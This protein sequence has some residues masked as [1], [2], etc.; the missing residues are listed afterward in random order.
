M[1]RS[2]RTQLRQISKLI[3]KRHQQNFSITINYLFE[4]TTQLY[5][6]VKY[7]LANLISIKYIDSIYSTN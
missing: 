5:K 4:S 2:I 6:G 7:T 1:I 3:Y